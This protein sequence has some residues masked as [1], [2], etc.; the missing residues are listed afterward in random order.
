MLT[1]KQF[2][3]EKSSGRIIL[4]GGIKGTAANWPEEQ[5][6]KNVPPYPGVTAGWL[7][8]GRGAL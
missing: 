1:V 8:Q 6:G 3:S 2:V 5:R 4:G 7:G